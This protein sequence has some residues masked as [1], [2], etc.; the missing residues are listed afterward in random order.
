MGELGRL[1]IC[2]IISILVVFSGSSTTEFN[3]HSVSF[4]KIAS[5][6]S[7]KISGLNRLL[8]L[9]PIGGKRSSQNPVAWQAIPFF[10]FNRSH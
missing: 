1:T 4:G 7:L 6:T 10:L 5:F 3:D 2:C 9:S 8:A